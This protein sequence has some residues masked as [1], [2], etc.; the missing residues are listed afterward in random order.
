MPGK[1]SDGLLQDTTVNENNTVTSK[2]CN[3]EKPPRVI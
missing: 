1:Y 3:H 2:N